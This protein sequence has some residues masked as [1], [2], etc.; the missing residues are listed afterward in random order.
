MILEGF[1]FAV[2]EIKYEYRVEYQYWSVNEEFQIVF[3]EKK[4]NDEISLYNY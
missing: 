4:R 1:L 3:F 2:S